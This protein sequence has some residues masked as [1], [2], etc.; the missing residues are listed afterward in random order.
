MIMCKIY[1]DVIII[2]IIITRCRAN[3]QEAEADEEEHPAEDRPGDHDPVGP[4]PVG[5]DSADQGRA[6]DCDWFKDVKPMKH[7]ISEHK[8][9]FPYI[10]KLGKNLDKTFNKDYSSIHF[11]YNLHQLSMID[12]IQDHLIRQGSFTLCETLSAESHVTKEYKL[13]KYFETITDLQNKITQKDLEP[14]IEWAS[15]KKDQLRTINS[16]LLFNLHKQQFIHL[17]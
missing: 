5:A 6:G 4:R 14:V 12:L 8:S 13:K 16:S 11:S 7:V 10:S 17:V 3:P 15:L 2:R 9:S 1:K